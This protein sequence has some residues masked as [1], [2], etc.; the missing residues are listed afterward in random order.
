MMALNM[1]LTTDGDGLGPGASAILAAWLESEG[2]AGLAEVSALVALGAPEPAELR[3]RLWAAGQSGAESPVAQDPRL[4]VL[5]ASARAG[6]KAETG[7][8]AASILNDEGWEGAD[9]LTRLVLALD[10]VGLRQQAL[11]VV[12]SR[13]IERVAA[14]G[15]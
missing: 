4:A 12:K 14:R 5:E 7:L 11:D 10:A 6:A 3:A 9:S 2:E 15:L 1:A 13:I 8:I